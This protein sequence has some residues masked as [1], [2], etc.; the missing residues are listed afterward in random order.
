MPYTNEVWISPKWNGKKNP[1]EGWWNNAV[2]FIVNYIAKR[3]KGKV[4]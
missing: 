1:N 3:V 2:E 4:K